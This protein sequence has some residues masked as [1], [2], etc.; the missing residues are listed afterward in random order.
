VEDEDKP[1]LDLG[2]EQRLDVSDAD[3]LRCSSETHVRRHIFQPCEELLVCPVDLETLAG[4]LSES[5]EDHERPEL[6]V[7]IAVLELLSDRTASLLA[8]QQR[9]HAL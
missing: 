6:A 4:V 9:P 1:F 8:D 5:S 7:D 3:A 2:I